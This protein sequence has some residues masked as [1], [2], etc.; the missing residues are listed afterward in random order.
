MRD[1]RVLLVVPTLGRRIDY[2]AGTLASIRSQDVPADIVVVAP[3]G[4]RA[5]R[6]L[7]A[8][9]DAT[10]LDDPGGLS[11]AI[12]HAIRS[13]GEGYQ[14][15]NWLGDDDE[16]TPGSLAATTGMLDADPGIAVAY[17]D[18]VYIDE[19]GRRLWVNR[20]GGWADR[21]LAW[22][23]NLIP[24][25][26]M[27]FRPSDFIEVGGLDESLQYAM[28]LDLLLKL[29]GRGRLVSVGSPVAA[30]RWHP[31]ST[32][33]AGRSASLSEADSIRRRYLPPRVRQFAP[34][35]EVPVHVATKVAAAR[36]NQR[37]SRLAGI[38]AK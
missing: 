27:L 29:R 7:A 25:P 11:A 38:Q 34:L 9:H 10:V 3:G 19:A 8:E 2:L 24:Q 21:V 30:F 6:D 35:W 18:C 16:L 17:G 15:A 23:P 1:A 31:D 32:T 37:A 13:L 14:Y 12:N 26:G 5:A 22:G 33:V 20:A 28:D 36:V 4:A